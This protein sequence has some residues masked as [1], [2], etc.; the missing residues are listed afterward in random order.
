M[1]IGATVTDTESGPAGAAGSASGAVKASV[2]ARQ[3]MSA[4]VPGTRHARAIGSP[5]RPLAKR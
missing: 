2:A 1:S 4:A 3:A 5:Y